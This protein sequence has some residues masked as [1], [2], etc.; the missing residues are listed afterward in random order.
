MHTVSGLTNGTAYAF[1]VR[2]VS[3]AAAGAAATA[4]ATPVDRAFG[5]SGTS[6]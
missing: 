1:E 2:A 5:S 3:G 6:S 4:T